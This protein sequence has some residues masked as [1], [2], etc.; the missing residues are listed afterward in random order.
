MSRRDAVGLSRQTN[1]ATKNAVV[2]YWVPVESGERGLS[3]ETLE[4]DETIG[5]RFPTGLDY[6][7]RYFEPSFQ[8]A[9]RLNSFPRVLAP[10]LG[11]PTSAATAEATAKKHTFDPSLV[12]PQ[13]HGVFMHTDIDGEVDTDDLFWSAISNELV[14]SCEPNDYLRFEQ[15]MIAIKDDDTVVSPTVTSDLSRRFAYHLIKTFISVEGGAE[16][17]IPTAGFSFTY[18]NDLG[19]DE[20]VLGSRD[21]Y[22]LP[23]GNVDGE[24]TFTPK[25]NLNAWYRR[26]LLLEPDSVKFRV[27]CEGDVIGTGVKQAVEIII[28]NTEAVEAPVDI[29]AGDPLTGVE[30][31]ARAAYDAGTGKFCTVAVTNTVASYA[32]T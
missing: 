23:L 32:T 7:S 27:L 12:D 2:G 28:H 31:T 4:I 15:N 29:D 26:A 11:D 20:I 3:R 24:L 1:L 16:T 21:L 30:I 9:V 19:T 14:I 8:G 18:T 10:T 22:K 13:P 25:T 17:E 5:N 6:G